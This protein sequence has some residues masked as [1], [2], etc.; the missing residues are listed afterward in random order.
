MNKK[1]FLYFLAF[2]AIFLFSCKSS[3][4]VSNEA[5]F[6]EYISGY[7]S[8]PLSKYSSIRVSLATASPVFDQ[9]DKDEVIKEIF[10]FSPKIEGT[11]HWVDKSTI[12]FKPTAPL[13][14]GES[15]I[16]EF[17]LSKVLKVKKEE[18]ENFKFK[19]RTIK[20]R[21]SFECGY[22][23]YKEDGSVEVK[24][25]LFLT[26]KDEDENIKKVLTAELNGKKVDI[27]WDKLSELKSGYQY[28]FSVQGIR[29]DL[30]KVQEIEFEW[31]GE[32]INSEN[33][34]SFKEEIASTNTFQY[35]G[36]KVINGED[37]HIEVYFNQVP[38]KQDF[39]NFC[40]ISSENTPCSFIQENSLLKIYPKKMFDSEKSMII[41]GMLKSTTG[42]TL[43]NDVTLYV[44]FESIQPAVKLLNNG[45]ILPTTDGIT[46]PFQAVNLS[47]IDVTVLKIE[48]N[49]TLQFLQ[50]N[51]LNGKS[52]MKRVAS[53][54]LRKKVILN[55]SAADLTQ[56]QTFSLDLS[57]II[58]KDPGAIYSVI[59]SFRKSY[60]LYPC[61]SEEVEQEDEDEYY[62]GIDKDWQQGEMG[63]Y[64]SDY[65]YDD[66][67]NDEDYDYSKR[68][69]PCYNEYYRQ[70]ERRA[71]TNILVSDLGVIAKAGSNNKMYVYVSN[72][73]TTEPESDAE[74][75]LYNYQQVPIC[76]ANTNS[77]GIAEIEYKVRPFFIE[78]SKNDQK[79]Y[80]KI[81][82]NSALSLSAFDVGGVVYDKGMK[83]YI[84]GERGV[85][86][87]GDDIYLSLLLQD[88]D[89]ML[90]GGHPITLELT[91]PKGQRYTKLMQKFETGKFIYSF[92]ISTEESVP[93]GNWNATFSIGGSTFKKSIKIETVK[94]N[95]LKITLNVD[96]NLIKSGSLAQFSLNA[97]WLHGGAAA[98]KEAKVSVKMRKATTAFPKFKD[99]T[100]ESPAA[101]N[102]TD[103]ERELCTGTTDANGNCTF[104]KEMPEIDNLP[105]MMEVSFSTRVFEGEGDFSI[106]Y[107]KANYSPFSEYVGI[108]AP[109][110]PNRNGIYYTGK[111][112]TF[113]VVRVSENGGLAEDNSHLHYRVYKL[114]WRWWWDSNNT[115]NLA[116]YINDEYADEFQEGDIYTTNGKGD[117]SLNINDDN[118][119]RYLILVSNPE[120]HVTGCISHFDWESCVGRAK[121]DD[122]QGATM[123][124]FSTDKDKYNVGDKIKIQIPTPNG[125]R[126]LVSLENRSKVISSQWVE[127][128]GMSNNTTLEIEATP[129]MV[130][131]VYVNIT[132]VQPHKNTVNDLPI[133]LYGVQNVNVE[134][135]NTVLT[136]VIKMADAIESEK[137]FEVNVSEK[138]G[139]EME[140]T[141]AIVDE[142]LLD[143][144]NFKTPNAHDDF[145]RREALGVN[146][147][148][149]YNMVI[150]AFG[151]KIE[152]LFSIGGDQD[153]K[154]ED[155]DKTNSRFKPVVKFIGP[156]KLG[157]KK[158]DKLV[159]ELPPY[160]GSVRVMVVACNDKAYGNAEKS[161][162]VQKPLMILATLPRVAGPKEDITLPVNIFSMDGKS[163][164]VT[165]TVNA[166]DIIG[167]EGN[168]TRS[169]A[170]SKSE[171]KIVTFSLK[172][173]NKLGKQ[174]ISITATD[175]KNKVN[176]EIWLEVRNPNPR[177]TI[178]TMY[179]FNA[180]E[181]K[182]LPYNL[183]GT[184]GSNTL[185]LEFATIPPINLDYRLKYL[186]GYPHGCAEQTSSKG[187]PQLF[188]PLLCDLTESEKEECSKNVDN[189]INKLTQMQLN[190]GSIAYWMGGNY[191]YQ[192]VTSYA[193]NFLIEAKNHG[194][195]VSASLLSDWAEYQKNKANNW[196]Y[197]NLNHYDYDEANDFTQAYRLYTLALYG[198]PEK[199]AMNRLKEDSRLSINAKWRL[200]GAYALCG[201]K[202]TAESILSSI[203]AQEE[204]AEENLY[205]QNFGSSFR[206][207]AMILETLCL[208]QKDREC[209]EMAQEISKEMMKDKWM[210]TQET[211][212][213]LIAIS[214]MTERAEASK[215]IKASYKQFNKAE[216]I[217][218]TK[219]VI[220]QDLSV[221]KP[222]E[223]KVSVTNQSNGTIFVTITE[224][225]L[226]AEDKTPAKE[227][228]LKMSIKY[229]NEDGRPV[230]I[231]RMKQGTDFIIQASVTNISTYED[232]KELSLIQIFPSGWEIFNERLNDENTNN[233][234]SNFSYQDIRDDRVMTY[235]NLDR[236]RTKT[237]YL[238][239]NAAYK[240][241]F[242]LPATSCEAMYDNEIAARNVGQWIEITD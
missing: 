49:N 77:E 60:S 8:G 108:R 1:L 87:P 208:L 150:G 110:S 105:G 237:F 134:N 5:D 177:N 178:S 224:S 167:V 12:E 93:T 213:A 156:C 84:Y 44:K 133:R 97:A 2:A 80:L 214:K 82:D 124:T 68:N 83:G 159:I 41:S 106:N 180:G 91:N 172:A 22:P 188:M 227:R 123:L 73:K 122:P 210:S 107:Q 4:E 174:K 88:Q 193:G 53:P 196:S 230:D 81:Q 67:W 151:G 232:Y 171:D 231:N 242:R 142:G 40:I 16:G 61:G 115:E 164:N 127:S 211:A 141:L 26:D 29:S 163:K 11:A 169:V 137:K 71:E 52:E 72:L 209:M 51:D 3:E 191:S 190:D 241:K 42:Q 17:H 173:G 7:T 37:A 46:L 198:K 25:R 168:K 217:N 50:V 47:A 59:L 212:Y 100:F 13:K 75:T 160:F 74:I 235:F 28:T 21:V 98:N 222:G 118:W 148:D 239:M 112:N 152:E 78:V 154:N 135:P 89:N 166:G 131:N 194:F 33:S 236:G 202:S 15:F 125:G 121:K 147:W 201:D 19:F 27:T 176:S 116:Y 158:T 144:T 199:G 162:K 145:F 207:K 175:G 203:V 38:A 113:E 206:D 215:S 34:D 45:V 153:L 143:L 216:S 234:N 32:P 136:P 102:F 36:N 54:V 226:P 79:G 48:T 186:I 70:S 223:G 31:D 6:L 35:I 205:G 95:R 179:Q 185:S 184:E 225:G 117:F 139:K 65:Y 228:G 187:F 114:S 23:I 218:S 146:T 94:P 99:Y 238:R 192:W 126:A 229:L 195:S 130:P 197:R 64:N 101:M 200:A 63:Y 104:K 204:T 129:D 9:Q 56:W 182:N 18:Q 161:V 220:K 39:E 57:E 132:L 128:N 69:N 14:N 10:E 119:G 55:E 183:F 62:E 76:K 92:K 170:F 181:T 43:K 30:E 189:A 140:Y 138:D 20:Q 155:Q 157:A 233:D 165:V 120:G 219:S 103:K 111:D 240:G 85:W 24:G 58:N 90:P 221:A 66:Y 96:K 86:R 149:M 109:K